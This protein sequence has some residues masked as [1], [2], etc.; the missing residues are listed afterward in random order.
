MGMKVRLVP[1]TEAEFSAYEQAEVQGY[2]DEN[3]RA[4]YWAVED[5][6]E[7]AWNEHRALLPQ[8]MHTTGHHL[9]R[10]V[11]AGSGQPVGSVW[12]FEDRGGSVP[13]AFLCHIVIDVP[14]RRRGHGSA[15]LVQ[16][17]EQARSLGMSSVGLHVAARNPEAI[18]VHERLGFRTAG[19][20]MVKSLVT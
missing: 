15:A 10:V 11:V 8:G 7:R 19:L 13:R 1:M 4:G 9:S 2:A 6:L 3:V 17:E 12:W 14:M 5:A 16:T 18:G 20:N